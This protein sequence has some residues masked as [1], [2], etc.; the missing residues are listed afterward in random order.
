MA[1]FG[2]LITAH[3]RGL[4]GR[5]GCLDAVAETLNARWGGGHSKGTISRKLHGSLDWTVRDIV[6]LEDAVGDYP[7]TRMLER[8]RA[9]AGIAIPACMIRQS[10][11]IS[12]E[13]GEAV[14]AILAAEQSECAG[15]RAEAIKE[16]GDAIAALTAAQR[17]LEG[18][19]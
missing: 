3:M 13:T 14:A 7:V 8:R 1:D 15:D 11:V 12:R 9:D 6:G 2:L 17:R 4:V 10:G 18:K 19:K 5:L 16:I